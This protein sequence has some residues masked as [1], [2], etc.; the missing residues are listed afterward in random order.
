MQKPRTKF[1]K[2]HHSEHMGMLP[3]I[4]NL[5]GKQGSICQI[6]YELCKC[7]DLVI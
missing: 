1:P 3:G 2:K 5:L 7:L 6:P 4:L